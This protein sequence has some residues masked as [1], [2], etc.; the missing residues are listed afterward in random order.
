M[1]KIVCSCGKIVVILVIIAILGFSRI[2]LKKAFDTKD[3]VFY[4]YSEA[5]SVTPSYSST[6]EG[7][8]SVQSKNSCQSAT[9]KK[10]ATTVVNAKIDTSSNRNGRVFLYHILCI[11][12]ICAL[13]TTITTLLVM[14]LKDDS[15]IRYEKLDMLKEA[16]KTFNC[17]NFN[18][19][20]E[21]STSE[22]NG[23]TKDSKK[24]ITTT[25]KSIK[26]DLIKHYMSCISEI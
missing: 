17:Q 20:E 3:F 2:V 21:T 14:L 11:I 5:S 24:T 19:Y 9:V 26:K 16:S 1:C 4:Q 12:Y 22:T 7:E 18:E 25:K 8:L 13:A 10:P 6:S 23:E 15:A